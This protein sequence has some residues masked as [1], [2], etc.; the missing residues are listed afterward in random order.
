MSLQDLF[1]DLFRPSKAKEKRERD[2]YV[3]GQADQ[4]AHALMAQDQAEA[5][6]FRTRMAWVGGV[7]VG[8]LLAVRWWEG[9][10]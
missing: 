5:A 4:R 9:S 7:T 6:T 10:R 1:D 8:L 3:I 2:A